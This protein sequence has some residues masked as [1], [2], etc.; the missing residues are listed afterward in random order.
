M[1]EFAFPKDI[2]GL[3]SFNRPMAGDAR[4]MAAKEELKT[5]CLSKDLPFAAAESLFAL[6]TFRTVFTKPLVFHRTLAK[7]RILVQEG[8]VIAIKNVA[9]NRDV[10]DCKKK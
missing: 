3:H 8:F 9:R 1:L 7:P 2:K 10:L 5:L 6:R 4:G